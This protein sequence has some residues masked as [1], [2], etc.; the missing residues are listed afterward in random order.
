MRAYLKNIYETKAN[1][2][3]TRKFNNFNLSEDK[4][5]NQDILNSYKKFRKFP[6]SKDFK[7]DIKYIINPFSFFK[8]NSSSNLLILKKNYDNILRKEFTYIKRKRDIKN[9]T[10]FQSQLRNKSIGSTREDNKEKKFKSRYKILIKN[11]SFNGSS[12]VYFKNLSN[13]ILDNLFRNKP[14]NSFNIIRPQ[15]TA[16]NYNRN[17]KYYYEK[18]LNIIKRNN[19]S[20]I[21][22]RENSNNNYA[23]I[24]DSIDLDYFINKNI[25]CEKN[26]DFTNET[27]KINF[28]NKILRYESKELFFEN[29]QNTPQTSTKEKILSK[30]KSI[31]NYINE[32]KKI[33]A[34]SKKSGKTTFGIKFSTLKMKLRKQN[35]VNSNLINNIKKEQSLSKYKLQVGIVKLNGYKPKNRRLK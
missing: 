19:S 30:N 11:L 18:L 22:E 6:F 4:R 14:Y 1:F 16:K 29:N 33:F 35:D 13:E 12:R 9:K 21:L 10:N 28:E 31:I 7:K 26:I 32:K 15:K 25:F 8:R 23:K 24:K 2:I 3:S 5:I 27:E 17:S 34:R 20:I